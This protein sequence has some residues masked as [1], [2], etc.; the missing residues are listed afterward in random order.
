MRGRKKNCD[1]APLELPSA[2]KICA[3][4]PDWSMNTKGQ[5]QFFLENLTKILRK[6][7]YYSYINKEIN[8]Y[9]NNKTVNKIYDG[10]NWWH[11]QFSLLFFPSASNS[12][13]EYGP[14]NQHILSTLLT[15]SYHWNYNLKRIFY[16][17]SL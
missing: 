13:S 16:S 12:H 1:R 4:I 6:K 15:D 8:L 5:P 2:M 17:I 9:V 7:I 3:W 10:I 14:C 11:F